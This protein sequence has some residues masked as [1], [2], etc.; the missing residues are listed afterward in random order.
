MTPIKRRNIFLALS[1]GH[2][3]IKPRKSRKKEKEKQD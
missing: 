2:A 1:V 3:T